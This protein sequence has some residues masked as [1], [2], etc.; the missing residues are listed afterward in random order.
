LQWFRAVVPGGC[1]LNTLSTDRILAIFN[2]GNVTL[3]EPTNKTAPT[4][5]PTV[6]NDEKNLIPYTKKS[7]PEKFFKFVPDKTDQ[8]N[9]SLTKVSASPSS[10]QTGLVNS[11]IINK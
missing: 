1:G 6:C 9:V 10:S 7:V 2:Y 8:L 4:T 5:A 3:A 11:W